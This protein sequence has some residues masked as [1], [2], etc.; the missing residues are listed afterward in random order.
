M[1]DLLKKIKIGE[2]S[3]LE[4]KD[5]KFSGNK[6][7]EPHTKSMADELAA[8][9]NSHDGAIVI[10][11]DD[12]TRMIYFDAQAVTN[13]S[14]DCLDK[15]LIDRFKTKYSSPDELTF[16]LKSKFITSDFNDKLYP[17]LTGILMACKN[18]E[19]YLPTAYIQAVS[20][21]GTERDAAYQIDAEDITGPL[22]Q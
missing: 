17:T 12:K 21:R 2:D 4:L 8:M 6:V 13:A 1:L 20:Y 14:I 22:D 10:G 11:V 18:P 5:L 3:C 7:S 15:D 19:E 16:L 9:A